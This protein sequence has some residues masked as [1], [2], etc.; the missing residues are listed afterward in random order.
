[1]AAETE[2]RGGAAVRP[3]LAEASPPTELRPRPRVTKRSGGP[4]RITVALL[5]ITVFLFLLT[6]LA[7][8]LGASPSAKPAARVLTVRR[9]YRTT[10]VKTVIT[11]SGPTGT[12][13][14]QSQS[15]SGSVAAAAAPVTRTS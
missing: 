9:I 6:V 12:S 13:V 2:L 4:D 15:S 7:R 14:S 5:S 10:V 8:Q 1:M 3:R 11:P